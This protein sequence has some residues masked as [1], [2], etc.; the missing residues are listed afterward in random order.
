MTVR[1]ISGLLAGLMLVGPMHAHVV[2]GGGFDDHLRGTNSGEVV[3]D[4]LPG[5]PEE[6]PAVGPSGGVVA[7]DSIQN[8][9]A[10]EYGA[11]EM[12]PVA[13][14]VQGGQKALFLPVQPRWQAQVD[15]LM[16][17]QGNIPSR[18]L[19]TDGATGAPALDINQAETEMAAGVR[20]G[21][22]L[23]LD[24]VYA[25]EGSYLNVS[26]FQGSASTPDGIYAQNNLAAPSLGPADGI[27]FTS[28]NVTTSGTIT[29]AELNWRRRTCSPVTWLAGFR[30]IEWNQG[31]FVKDQFEFDPLYPEPPGSSNLDVSTGNSLYGGQIGMD[32]CLWNRPSSAIQINGVGKAGV[33]YNHASYQRTVGTFVQ[34]GR[35]PEVLGPAAA[36][37]DQTSFV[38][39]VGVNA[40]LRITDWLSWRAGYTLFWLSCVATPS[41]QLSVTNVVDNPPTALIDTNGSVLLHGVTTG[42]EARW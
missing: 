23:N 20:Y 13:G 10:G 9:G 22:L 37:A 4:S 40:S 11:T 14:V 28:A 42:L 33:F 39:E 31:M 25:I 7:G 24:P 5:I 6:V 3:G 17:W 38:G 16:L 34:D 1:T 18:V 27:L 2:M 19:Y 29:G 32:L 30:W 15:A 26:S 12:A 35:D 8:A 36:T 21:L 41:D